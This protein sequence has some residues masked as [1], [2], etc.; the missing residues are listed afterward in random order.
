M[1]Q[2]RKRNSPINEERLKDWVDRFADYRRRPTEEDLQNWLSQFDADDQDFAARILD[3]VEVVSNEQI[4]EGYRNILDRLPGWDRARSRRMG[5][6]YFVGFGRASE[7]GGHMLRVFREANNLAAQQHD[8][9]FR[10]IQELVGLGL[11]IEDTVVFVDDFAGS[12]K[13]ACEY[14]P[15]VREL[16]ASDATIYLLLTACT[17]TAIERITSETDAKLVASLILEDA[18]NVFASKC[19]LLNSREKTALMKY[20]MT[21][22]KKNPKG[23][24]DCG[25]LLVLSHRT[26]NNTIPI[27]HVDKGRWRG[28]FPRYMVR[29]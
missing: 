17:Q 3:S 13:Q 10:N 18:D 6:W 26:P 7:S 29:D 20:C 9:L 8:D 27:L 5:N 22:D 28:L 11:G 1:R 21:A 12:G 2:P 24:G 23:Y 25:L 16:V 15:T 14:W 4:F 19:K